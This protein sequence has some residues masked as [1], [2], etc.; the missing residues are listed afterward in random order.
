[1][2]NDSLNENGCLVRILLKCD[3]AVLKFV[4]ENCILFLISKQMQTKMPK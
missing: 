1:M 3:K 4:L 2:M